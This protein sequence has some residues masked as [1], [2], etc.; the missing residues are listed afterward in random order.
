MKQ[1][2]TAKELALKQFCSYEMAEKMLVFTFPKNTIKMSFNKE[3][4]LCNVGE[5]VDMGFLKSEKIIPAISTVEALLLVESFVN[6]QTEPELWREGN[7]YGISYK[8]E[9]FTSEY[10]SDIFCWLLLQ[11]KEKVQEGLNK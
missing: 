11:F 4:N 6:I 1:S 8:E 2:L 7:M 5:L 3:K 9:Q 10:V